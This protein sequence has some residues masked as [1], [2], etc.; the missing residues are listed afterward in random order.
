MGGCNERG[1]LHINIQEEGPVVTSAFREEMQAAGL[2][3]HVGREQQ[4][5]G[6]TLCS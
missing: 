1:R 6:R 2:V 5:L 3:R 4:R